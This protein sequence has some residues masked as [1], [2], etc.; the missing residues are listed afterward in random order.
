MNAI[1]SFLALIGACFALSFITPANAQAPAGLPDFAD[2]VEKNGAAVVNVST[3]ARGGRNPMAD[4]DEDDP[5]YEFYR[6][7]FQIP[8]GGRQGQQR[9]R[10]PPLRDYGQGSG[11]IVTAD[12]FILTNA[13]VVRRAEEITVT[14]N[15]KREFKARLVGADDRTD[16]AVLKIEAT[17]LPM[18]RIGDPNKARVG[19]WVLAIGSPFGLENTVTA[20]II[21][22]K[23]RN[24]FAGNNTGSDVRFIQTDVAVNPGNSGG[25][26]FNLRGEVIGINSQIYSR[27]GGYQGISFAIPI[28]V[29][30]NIYGQIKS[31]GKVTRGRIGVQ[32]GPVTRDVAEALGLAK[33]AGAYVA[34]VVKDTPAA[35]GGVKQGDVI[36]K[37]DGRDMEDSNDVRR[38]IANVRPGTRVTLTIFREGKTREVMLVTDELVE[39]ETPAREPAKADPKAKGDAKNERLGVAVSELTAEQKRELKVDAGAVVQAVSGAAEQVLRPGEVI[40]RVNNTEITSAKQFRE[41]VA[42]VDTKKPVA[43]LVRFI[44]ERSNATEKPEPTTSLRILRMN[45]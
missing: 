18:V 37:V 43:L 22:S 7:F 27:S 45:E 19:E 21:S 5:M 29:A 8:P 30:M 2:L 33:P 15:D 13:H 20:G 16:T 28:D 3:K 32:I 35:K 23:G 44:P 39:T 17:G 38:S 4:L 1:K 11:F 36:L 9:D 40:V 12:G 24:T 41:V 26:L 6:R 42:K 25:P 34:D 14:L 10:E 31:G